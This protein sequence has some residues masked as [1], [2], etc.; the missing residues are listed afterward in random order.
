MH[1]AL[2][3]EERQRSTAYLSCEAKPC[4]NRA[5]SM[6]SSLSTEPPVENPA[7]TCPDSVE[8]P[9]KPAMP[10]A[11]AS[12]TVRVAGGCSSAA[13]RSNSRDT[14]RATSRSVADLVARTAMMFRNPFGWAAQT[15]L[16]RQARRSQAV[17][18]VYTLPDGN[19]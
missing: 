14:S 10:R 3:P 17:T 7:S 11:T 16:Y 1:P 8:L 13:R 4:S 6:S 12:D 18:N 5:A 2:N 19:R 9:N 15:S